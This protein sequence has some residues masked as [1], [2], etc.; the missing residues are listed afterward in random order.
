LA[1][2]LFSC[3]NSAE[4]LAGFI[5]RIQET[6][7]Q[8]SRGSVLTVL[9]RGKHSNP[10]AVIDR[11]LEK[12]S[13]AAVSGFLLECLGWCTVP[14]LTP[15]TPSH[16]N[17]T[18]FLFFQHDSLDQS[19]QLPSGTELLG[20]RSPPDSSQCFPPVPMYN[21]AAIWTLDSKPAIHQLL[22]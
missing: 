21:F 11:H 2:P 15:V 22:I 3:L 6:S 9:S 1:E 7:H 12:V 5:R 17:S 20:R 8:S 14:T 13:A 10:A 4:F 16:R 19:I 18:V